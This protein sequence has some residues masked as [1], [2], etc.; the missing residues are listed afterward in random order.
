[1]AIMVILSVVLNS[2]WM[3]LMIKM[4]A[5][6]IKRAIYPPTEE[7]PTEKIELVKADGLAIDNEA[8]CGSSTQGSNFAD[9][10]PDEGGASD[11]EAI[12]NDV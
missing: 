9:E 6:V 5:R 2:Y 4:I 10:I 1:M 8:D 7:D 3:W 12:G 11:K